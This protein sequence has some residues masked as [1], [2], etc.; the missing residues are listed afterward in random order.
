M[1]AGAAAPGAEL[2]G[3]FWKNQLLLQSHDCIHNCIVLWQ[4]EVAL[5]VAPD[6]GT[7]SH[8]Y[9]SGNESWKHKAGIIHLLQWKNTSGQHF[10]SKIYT[11]WEIRYCY[12]RA[13]LRKQVAAPISP[14]QS[15]ESL[16]C[17][18]AQQYGCPGLGLIIFEGETKE[19]IMS[20]TQSAK[21]ISDTH[22]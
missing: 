19:D 14:L 16:E 4:W 21:A 12:F 7:W 1:E 11:H 10:L 15:L 6:L 3:W 5:G 13:I 22:H 18:C 17:P 20:Q 2:R 9:S 8:H